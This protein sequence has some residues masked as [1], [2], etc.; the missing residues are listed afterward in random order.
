MNTKGVHWQMLKKTKAGIVKFERTK[1]KRPN[2]D[3]HDHT[4]KM[5]ASV[6]K[7]SK[8]SRKLEI[9]GSM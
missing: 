3:F 1:T 6:F 5:L 2:G 7:S 9:N 4:L 8:A